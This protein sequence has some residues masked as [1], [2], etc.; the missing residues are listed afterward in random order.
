MF[1][2]VRCQKGGPTLNIIVSMLD[3][4]SS[5]KHQ[6]EPDKEFKQKSYMALLIEAGTCIVGVGGLKGCVH[7]SKDAESMPRF[8]PDPCHSLS[9][10]NCG[11][12]DRHASCIVHIHSCSCTYS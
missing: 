2:T 9:S 11:Y 3:R 1:C 7:D 5:S 6:G 12:P 8:P 4:S 10:S